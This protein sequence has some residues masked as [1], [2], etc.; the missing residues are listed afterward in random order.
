MMQPQQPTP[1]DYLGTRTLQHNTW[2]VGGTYL[3]GPKGCDNG[4]R[5]V[6]I[7]PG[8]EEIAEGR[9]DEDGVYQSIH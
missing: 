9:G 3:C 4:G 6:N 2:W 1:T 5:E 7:G 8:Y